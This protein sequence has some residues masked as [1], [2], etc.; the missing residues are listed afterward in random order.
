[1]DE[2]AHC[3]RLL[4]FRI[5]GVNDYAAGPKWYFRVKVLVYGPIWLGL[6]MKLLQ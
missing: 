5:Q 1:M 2:G 4:N 6:N 3:Q